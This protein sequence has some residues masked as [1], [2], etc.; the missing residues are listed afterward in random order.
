MK[1]MIRIIGTIALV[2]LGTLG[3]AHAGV[4]PGGIAPD[5][6]DTYT[7]RKGDT[8]WGIAKRFLRDPWRWPD[9][10]QMNRA[11]IR[12]PHLIYPGQILVFDRAAGVLRT[13]KPVGPIDEK[14]SPQVRH[15]PIQDAIPSIPLAAIEPFLVRPQVIDQKTLENSGRIVGLEDGRWMAGA[16][17]VAFAIGVPEDTRL[18]QLFRPAEPL[19]ARDGKTLIGYEARYLG[20]AKVEP[21]DDPRL[22]TVLRLQQTN[23]AIQPGDALI[24]SQKETLVNFVPRAP[25]H[26]VDARIIKLYQGSLAAGRL[27]VILLDQGEAQDLAPGHVLA[28]W[29]VRPPVT[30]EENRNTKVFLPEERYGV[31]FVFRVFERMSYALVMETEKPVRVG[32]AARTP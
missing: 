18:V 26:D 23:E 5:A 24:A 11:E 19:H 30:D 25:E 14:R 15:E 1:R 13:A 31:A 4:E 9:L 29:R 6:P 22:G 16:G 32:D 3:F 12:N 20:T 8:L 28:L 10:W 17:D 2:W 7:V 21:N 27:D